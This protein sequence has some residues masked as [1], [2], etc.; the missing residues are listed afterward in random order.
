M[1]VIPFS[2]MLADFYEVLGFSQDTC[3]G[4]TLLV[5]WDS[6]DPLLSWHAV[7]TSPGETIPACDGQLRIGRPLGLALMQCLGVSVLPNLRSCT[8]VCEREQLMTTNVCLYTEITQFQEILG[9]LEN[10]PP[11]P[12]L[13]QRQRESMS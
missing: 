10:I 8:I 13:M 11:L 4:F 3:S 5:E 7:P 12:L 2:S 6:Q 1:A 9:C